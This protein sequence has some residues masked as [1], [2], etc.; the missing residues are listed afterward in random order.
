MSERQARYPG[1][2]PFQDTVMDRRLFF[3]RA[4]EIETL[5]R[6]VLDNRLVVLFGRDRIGKTSLLQAG[7]F[8][9]LREQNLLPLAV[10]MPVPFLPETLIAAVGAACQVAEINQTPAE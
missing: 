1:A 5:C 6:Q 9:R 10:S 3:G 2:R 8:P 4:W 7:L